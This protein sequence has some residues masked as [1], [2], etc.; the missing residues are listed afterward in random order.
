M[1]KLDISKAYDRLNWDFLTGILKSYAFDQRW[2]NWVL[3]MVSSLVYSIFLNGSPTRT[4][5]R[6]LGLRQGDLISPFLFI[7]AAKG[8]GHYLNSEASAS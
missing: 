6:S 2:I 4:F 7:L 8:L 1:I 5:N 3:A